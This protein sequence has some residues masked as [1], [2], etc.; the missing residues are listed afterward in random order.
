MVL[1]KIPGKVINQEGADQVDQRVEKMKPEGAYSPCPVQHIGELQERADAGRRIC[2]PGLPGVDSGI[3]DDD[4][5]VV[6]LE[7][8]PEGLPVG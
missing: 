4:V 6:K 3:A 2:E 8:A 1:E 7:Y 5:E